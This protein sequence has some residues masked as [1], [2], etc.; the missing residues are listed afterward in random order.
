MRGLFTL[1]PPSSA[2]FSGESSGRFNVGRRS[3][4]GEPMLDI[5]TSRGVV[6][7]RVLGEFGEPHQP[8]PEIVS[9]LNTAFPS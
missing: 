1:S 5:S 9:R 8:G 7:P 6:T 2:G 4:Q 3:F